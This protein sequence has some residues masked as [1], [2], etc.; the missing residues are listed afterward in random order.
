MNIKD[1]VK[2]GKKV[3][4]KRIQNENLIY[5]TECGFEFRVPLEDTGDGVF[6]SED[7]AMLFMRYI[8]KELSN[9]EK[10]EKVYFSRFRKNEAFFVT[11]DGFEFPVPVNEGHILHS[12]DDKAN[13]SSYIDA[14]LQSIQ[15]EKANQK[16]SQ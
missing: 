6:L 16:A 12:V 2:D 3:Y 1:M 4:F 7:K 10:Q 14:H 9:L 11:E 5:V 8:R 15:E 13:F